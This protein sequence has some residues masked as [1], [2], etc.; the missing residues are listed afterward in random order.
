MLG[1]AYYR[2]G[3]YTRAIGS[4]EKAARV[5]PL[6]PCDLAFFAMAQSRLGHVAQARNLLEAAI[7]LA[8]EWAHS[9]KND[10]VAEQPKGAGWYEKVQNPIVVG[11]AHG[12]IEA[13]RL[14]AIVGTS[15]QATR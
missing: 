10:L 4:F 2:A 9:D 14:P 1:A 12:V 6:K 15:P 3:D 5:S 8:D 7:R 11:K 13:G